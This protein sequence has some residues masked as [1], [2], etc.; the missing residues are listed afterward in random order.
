MDLLINM[1]TLNVYLLVMKTL[2]YSQ[3]RLS[4]SEQSETEKEIA[5]NEFN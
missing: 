5:W 4:V 1:E 3:S 2:R